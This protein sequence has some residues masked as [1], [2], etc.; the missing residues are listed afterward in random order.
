MAYSNP[1]LVDCG[2]PQRKDPSFTRRGKQRAQGRCF[3][4]PRQV[5][6][7]RHDLLTD[8][9]MAWEFRYEVHGTW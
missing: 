1:A 4:S 6:H 7:S 2:V 5:S 9:S 8:A 3:P